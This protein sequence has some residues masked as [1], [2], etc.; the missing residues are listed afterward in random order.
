M[1][2]YKNITLVTLL[3]SSMLVGSGASAQVT[4]ASKAQVKISGYTE[5]DYRA[6]QTK[7]NLSRTYQPLGG[8]YDTASANTTLAGDGR[9]MGHET[10]VRF[11]TDH[12]LE[13]GLTATAM[14]ELRRNVWEER[15]VRIGATDGTWL[16][17]AGNDVPRGI[18][19]VRTINPTVN[20]RVTDIAGSSTGLIDVMDSSSSNQNFGLQIGKVIPGALSF[21]FMPNSV[22]ALDTGTDTGGVSNAGE[23]RFSVGY[24]VDVGNTRI[25]VGLLRGDNKSTNAAKGD[26][27]AKTIGIRHTA[28]PISA[29][30]QYHD[31]EAARV[32]AA[33]TT[34]EQKTASITYALNKEIS[35]GYAKTRA[36][37]IIAGVTGSGKVDQDLLQAAY[38]LGPAVIQFDYAQVENPQYVNG[39]DMTILKAKV[40]VNF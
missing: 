1:K 31:N 23:S 14:A 21:S 36:E 40:K 27:E 16:F 37:N 32:T 33:S 25:G 34:Q 3:A 7:G 26:S 2:K 6:G 17:F 5:A 30:F 20:N 35:V 19:I 29:G 12:P 15:E 28:G 11:Q 38:N 13:G 10:S 18:E 22:N 39:T 4:S 8:L 24:L 9:N